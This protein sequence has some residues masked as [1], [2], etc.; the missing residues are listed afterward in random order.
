MVRVKLW[1]VAVVATTAVYMKLPPSLPAVLIMS[2]T[3]MLQMLALEGAVE[4]Y[5]A[6][7]NKR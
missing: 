2:V 3:Y 4:R 1:V 5:A 7:K 6:E